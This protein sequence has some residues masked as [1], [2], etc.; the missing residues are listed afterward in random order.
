MQIGLPNLRRL[1][2]FFVSVDVAGVKDFNKTETVTG[3]AMR[4]MLYY[5]IMTVE[6][7]KDPTKGYTRAPEYIRAAA[8]AI[9]TYGDRDTPADVMPDSHITA[10][11]STLQYVKDC[12][13]QAI[14]N[15]IIAHGHA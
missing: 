13:V 5:D 15:L 1:Y 11:E 7:V 3:F 4:N 8:S 12:D 10:Y 2:I 6:G 14:I 9:F